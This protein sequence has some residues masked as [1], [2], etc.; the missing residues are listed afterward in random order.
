MQLLSQGE[1]KGEVCFRERRISALRKFN[2]L[3]VAECLCKV[4]LFR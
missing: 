2:D 3:H 4:Q 1:R